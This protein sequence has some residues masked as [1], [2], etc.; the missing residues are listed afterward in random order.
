MIQ[1]L[2]ESYSVKTL[3]NAFGVH[4]SSYK[5]WAERPHAIDTERIHL[6]SE[7]RAAHAESNGSA[8]ARTIADIVT[9]KGTSLSRY[10]AGKL[11]KQLELVS[12]Q[13]PKHAYKKRIRSMSLLRI[14]WI[15]NLPLTNRIKSGV[16]M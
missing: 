10:R 11:M 5:Y 14:N 6:L 8:G 12:C 15:G 9:T 1:Q 4:R 16:A 3:C 13:V 2:N 7:V